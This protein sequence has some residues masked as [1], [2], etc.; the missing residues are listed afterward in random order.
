MEKGALQLPVESAIWFWTQ[1]H[2]CG[3]WENQAS[4]VSENQDR[5]Q[6]LLKVRQKKTKQKK[7]GR[8]LVRGTAEPSKGGF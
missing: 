6:K 2:V 5:Q 8:T 3:A 7:P 1:N 4:F